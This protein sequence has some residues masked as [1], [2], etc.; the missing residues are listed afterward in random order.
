MHFITKTT[1]V[2]NKIINK[3][4]VVVDQVSFTLTSQIFTLRRG[5]PFFLYTYL[6]SNML[7]RLKSI[8]HHFFICPILFNFNSFAQELQNIQV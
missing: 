6:Q 5:T 3:K 7:P 2:T 1:P 8:G 4:Y